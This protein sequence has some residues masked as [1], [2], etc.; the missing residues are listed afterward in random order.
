MKRTI[1][2][3]AGMALGMIA[4][5]MIAVGMIAVGASAATKHSATKHSAQNGPPACGALSFRAV[6]AGAADGDQQAGFYR[7][8]YGSLALHADVKQ[9]KAVDYFV[10]ADGKRLGAAPANLPDWATNCAAAKK[11]PAP[12]AAGASS[13]TGDRFRVVLAHQGGTRLALLYG[14]DGATWRFCNT[15]GY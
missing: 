5:G 9:G 8:R 4:L 14:L 7:S 6:A 3:C 1:S 15:G 11:L 10:L 12:V 2:A 13:C